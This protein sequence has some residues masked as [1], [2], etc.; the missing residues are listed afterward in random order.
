MLEN[1]LNILKKYEEKHQQ[2]SRLVRSETSKNKAVYDI[3]QKKSY[4]INKDITIIND[5][6]E[7]V[8][9]NLEIVCDELF[10][11]ENSEFNDER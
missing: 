10:L 9:I 11:E 1:N 6:I 5:E 3:C 2:S 4:T 7:N 8:Y